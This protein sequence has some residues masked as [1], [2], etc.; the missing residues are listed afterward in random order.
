MF[1]LHVNGHSHTRGTPGRIA[2]F[3]GR[4]TEHSG[5]YLNLNRAAPKSSQFNVDPYMCGDC[6]FIN[7]YGVTFGSRG[8]SK[9]QR[10]VD[11]AD[12]IHCHD[13]AY[14]NF[15]A[16]LLNSKKALC[17]HAHI[18]SVIPR[19][20]ETGRF[21]Y[22]K[23]VGHAMITNG[24]GRLCDDKRWGRLPD[25][26]DIHHPLYTPQYDLRP[27]KCKV[28]YT[29]SNKF[30]PASNRINAKSPAGTKKEIEKVEGI[31][32]RMVS[33]VSFEES[34]AEKITSHI[35][36]DEI[37]SPYTHLSTLEGACVGACVLVNYDATTAKELCK[38]VGAPVESYPFVKV[39]PKTVRE[40][41]EY[42]RDN[43]RERE[44]RGREAREWMLRYYEPRRL[45][46]TYERFYS[47]RCRG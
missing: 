25:I 44:E 31:D 40:K 27:K 10:L 1:V 29:Y 32:L 26:L 46:E 14:P 5:A 33:G 16:G 9:M 2:S 8:G 35:V 15:Q 12:V 34:M 43:P 36:L 37:F 30:E 13:A 17:Y 38:A 19:F 20:F 18:G 42:F 22:E 21:R 47:S 6:A 4:Y 11:K 24:Y 28:V 41:I 23:R 3:W 39:T 45:L 7:P